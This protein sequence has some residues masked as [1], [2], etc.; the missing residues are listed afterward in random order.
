[1]KR[2]RSA[3][4]E[5]LTKNGSWSGYREFKYPPER[6]TVRAKDGKD[7]CFVWHKDEERYFLELQ[8][9]IRKGVYFTF[10]ETEHKVKIP[11]INLKQLANMGIG[12]QVI[13]FAAEYANNK[14]K[15]LMILLCSNFWLIDHMKKNFTTAEITI[16]DFS[17]ET[18]KQLPISELDPFDHFEQYLVKIDDPYPAEIIFTFD[19][20]SGVF[21]ADKATNI[22]LKRQS[23]GEFVLAYQLDDEELPIHEYQLY[24]WNVVTTINV[25]AAATKDETVAVSPS[26]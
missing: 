20:A 19:S 15:D 21:I 18:H 17:R 8:G 10:Y 4:S 13:K 14:E 23:S 16:Y 9:I 24:C 12:S 1:M 26:R 11:D 25:A 6:L 7:Y 22:S 5:N 2:K 3:Y